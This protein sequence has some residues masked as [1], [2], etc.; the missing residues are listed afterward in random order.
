MRLRQKVQA[1]PRETGLKTDRDR[2]SVVAGILI[3]SSDQVLIAD[4]TRSRNLREY[5]EFPGGKLFKGES[6]ELALTRELSEELGITVTDASFFDA[7]EHDY[8]D[9]AVSIDFFRVTG[10][11]G[12]P[13]GREGQRLR[14]V[15]RTSLHEQKLLPADLLVVQKLVS[16]RD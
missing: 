10:W 2:V 6:A 8:A 12:E 3:D 9:I 5:F 13:T 4:R 14:W 11:E 1:M 16:L 7:I 15:K